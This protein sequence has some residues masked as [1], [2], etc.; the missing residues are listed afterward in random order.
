MAYWNYFAML[1]ILP[2]T[3]LVKI[4]GVQLDELS[5]YFLVSSIGVVGNGHLGQLPQQHAKWGGH[6]PH[7]IQNY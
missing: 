7:T 4:C 6:C 1:L 3:C 5:A 2:L